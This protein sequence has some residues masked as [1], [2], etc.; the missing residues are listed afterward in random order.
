M[1]LAPGKGG[2]FVASPDGGYLALVRPDTIELTHA[3]GTSSGS[4]VITYTPVITYSEYAY[5]AA[6]VWRADSSEVAAAIPSPDP[7]ATPLT[8]SVWRLPVGGSASTA[9]TISGQFFFFGTGDEPLVSPDL[10]RVA[11]TRSTATP[12]IYSLH[13]AA[14]DGTAEV[15]V[16]TGDVVWGGWAPDAAHFTFSLGGP[17][18]LQLGDVSGASSPLVNGT[19][20]EWF[21]S[22]EFLFLS[23]AMGGWTIQRGGIGLPSS[24]LASPAGDFVQFDFVYR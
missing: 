24:P 19:D 7:F 1:L 16:S 21:S 13:I 10:A 5:Y 6:P 18:S 15:L 20:L 4:G 22:T 14:A 2:D 12:N 11:F 9:G 17:L 8:G 3:D 23:G